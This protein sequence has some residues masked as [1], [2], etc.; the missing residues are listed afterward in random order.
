MSATSWRLKNV[1]TALKI[2]DALSFPRSQLRGFQKSQKKTMIVSEENND[3]HD[4]HLDEI[5][6]TGKKMPSRGI[7]GEISG[8]N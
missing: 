1:S 8:R 3:T 5:R 4:S 6:M 2:Y 7:Y